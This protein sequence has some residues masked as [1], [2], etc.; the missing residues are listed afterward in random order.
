M[1][2]ASTG[3]PRSMSRSIDAVSGEAGAVSIARVHA[4]EPF[5]GDYGRASVKERGREIGSPAATVPTSRQIPPI[6]S[7]CSRSR[8]APLRLL[9]RQS[10]GQRRG[11][12]CA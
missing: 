5:P 11:W 6:S 2:S 3:A 9:A 4:A 7:A 8:I 1:W 12:H 10:R